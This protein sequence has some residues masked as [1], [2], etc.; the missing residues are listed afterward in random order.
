MTVARI[1][2]RSHAIRT[3]KK[4]ECTRRPPLKG[5]SPLL[6]ML[7]QPPPRQT[8]RPFLIPTRAREREAMDALIITDQPLVAIGLRTALTSSLP[9]RRVVIDRSHVIGEAPPAEGY[10][11]VLLDLDVRRSERIAT[12][13]QLRRRHPRATI[14]ALTASPDSDEAEAA[15]RAGA[16]AYLSK[17][18]ALEELRENLTRAIA[19]QQ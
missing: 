6:G 8:S 13:E 15:G 10:N 4:E 9:V 18:A 3:Q 11:L 16:V 19:V 7:M 1:T 5:E 12:L 2:G 14:A 17:T